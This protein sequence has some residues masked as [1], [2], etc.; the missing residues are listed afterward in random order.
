MSY[1]PHGDGNG[2]IVKCQCL[3]TAK[4]GSLW[5]RD[6]H[7]VFREPGEVSRHGAKAILK[8]HSDK[9]KTLAFWSRPDYPSDTSHTCMWQER[10]LL[11]PP[12]V[13]LSGEFFSHSCW[14]NHNLWTKWL[15]LNNV[16]SLPALT[17]F[18]L[19]GEGKNRKQKTNNQTNKKKP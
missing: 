5:G 6:S 15:P 11:T 19:H 14:C 1:I 10:R 12:R 17:R 3:T 7:V 16:L 8:V 18:P 13:H 9:P 2:I 4:Q